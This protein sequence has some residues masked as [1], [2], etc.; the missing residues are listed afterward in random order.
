MKLPR[1][2]S[3]RELIRA[4]GRLG[5]HV[6]RQTGSHVQL[7]NDSLHVT[8]PMHNPVRAGTLKSILRQANVTVE[9]LVEVL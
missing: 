2:I 9:Q 3:G 6:E 8:V 4:L 5:F 1:D 7:S